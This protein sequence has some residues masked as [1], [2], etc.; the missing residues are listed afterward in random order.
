M[1][2]HNQTTVIF[3][4]N[5]RVALETA[6]VLAM[7]GKPLLL[8]ARNPVELKANLFDLRSKS[9]RP[10]SISSMVADISD[11]ACDALVIAES[12]RLGGASCFFVCVGWM[13]TQG[14][15]DKDPATANLVTSTN[16]SDPARFCSSAASF[17][18]ARGSG[19]SVCAVTSAAGVRGRSANRTYGAA[20]ALLMHSLEALR[21]EHSKNGVKILDIRLGRVRTPMTQG[22]QGPLFS[23]PKTVGPMIAKAIES[24]SEGAVYVPWLWLPIMTIIRHLPF[25]VFSRMRV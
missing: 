25:F 8:V 15:C 22:M 16:G 12:E 14:E 2:K 4:A 17:L 19:G 1:T 10:E 9:P 24:S 3:G 23:D 18:S 5:S 13:P 11:P 6:R 20:K 7:A 21:H